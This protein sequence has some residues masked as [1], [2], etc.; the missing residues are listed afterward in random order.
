MS[1][2]TLEAAV[3]DHVRP[4]LVFN[5]DIFD[6]PRLRKNLH[7]GFKSLHA[8]APDIF[9][10]PANGGH[11]MVTRYDMMSEILRD[12]E[13]FSNSAMDIPKTNSDYVMIPLNMD[14]PE[15]APYRAV[16][17]RYFAPKAVASLEERMRVW[18][19]R[20][21]DGVA[22]GTSCDLATIGAAFPVSVFMEMMGLPMDRFEDFRDLVVE[23]FGNITVARRIEIQGEIFGEMTAIIEQRRLERRD[24]LISRLLDE[25]VNGRPLTLAELQSI[26][27]LLF[28]AGLDTVANTMAFAMRH[29][30]EDAPLQARLRREPS[31]IPSFVE[32]SL[33]VYAIVNGTRTVKRDFEYQGASFRTGDMVVCSLPLGGMDERKNP[34]PMRFDIDRK[35]RQ[36]VTF[37]IGPHLCVGHY[38]GRAEM[39]IFTEEWLK[40]VP[41]FRMQEGFVPEFRAGLVMALKKVPVEWGSAS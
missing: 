28:I 7:A 32:E 12:S 25:E 17:M 38:L 18:A 1:V 11:W 27:F 2:D 31:A 16:L 4:D 10:T 41:T 14:P 34:D 21:I 33:R 8:E 22:S 20:L 19:A 35:D 37:S 30:A 5:F 15:H 40:R 29:L 36:L 9:Y 6:D 39:R 23:F 24:D 13:H 26:C 3:P